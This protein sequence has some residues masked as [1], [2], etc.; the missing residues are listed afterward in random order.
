MLDRKAV[1]APDDNQIGLGPGH[2]EWIAGLRAFDRVDRR[3]PRAL[4]ATFAK[5]AFDPSA[6]FLISRRSDHSMQLA[7]LKIDADAP[8]AERGQSECRQL[9]PV[10]AVAHGRLP[11]EAPSSRPRAV[12]ALV[13]HGNSNPFEHALYRSRQAS[14]ERKG[15]SG[16]WRFGSI[17][18]LGQPRVARRA[19][20]VRFAQDGH[21]ARRCH[22]FGRHP[23]KPVT[24][25]IAV[26]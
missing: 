5:Q 12:P 2:R 19:P 8:V 6:R 24:E 14:C 15:C 18:W 11:L 7:S 23:E 3:L 1:A 10:S 13:R 20:I 16:G 22:S 26:Q 4:V 9:G 25:C 17:L 21:A